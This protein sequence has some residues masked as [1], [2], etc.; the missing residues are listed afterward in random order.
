MRFTLAH[1]VLLA[2]L[3][4]VPALGADDEILTLERAL[5]R[6]REVNPQLAGFAFEIKAQEARATQ[7]GLRPAPQAELLVEDVAGTGDHQGFDAAQ[8]TLSLSQVLE[9]GGKRGARSE[10]AA[11]QRAALGTEQAVLQLDVA[12]DVARRFVATAARQER[13]DVA[14]DALAV[15]EKTQAA[16]EERVRAAAAPE[17]ERHRARV[18]TAEARLDLEDAGHALATA[19]HE[20]AAAIGL[21]AP[22]FG[23]VTAALYTTPGSAPLDG[24]LAKLESS[25]DL[26]RYADEARLK[27]AELRLA[28]SQRSGDLRATLGAR[29]FEQDGDT[30]FLAGISLPLFAGSRAAPAVAAAQAQADQVASRRQAAMLKAR[31]HVFAQYQEMEHARHV[32]TALRDEMLPALATALEQTEYAYRRGRYSY[33]ELSDAQRRLNEARVRLI[34]AATDFHIRR[35]EIERLTGESLGEPGVQP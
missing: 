33:L 18:A 7:A 11:A 12:A 30:A 4:A 23:R 5:A 22:D 16:V 24:L 28:R 21:A 8:T 20:L 15:A 17:A 14:R 6:A 13:L 25:P 26:L 1:A 19:R 35:I 10:A 2:C 32:T 29:R 3:T 27:D 31:A 9:L 34:A